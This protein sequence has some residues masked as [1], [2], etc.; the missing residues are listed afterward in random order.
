MAASVEST[1]RAPLPLHGTNRGE[2]QRVAN[3]CAVRLRGKLIE[4][5]APSADRPPRAPLFGVACRPRRAN[6][7]PGP[8]CGRFLSGALTCL[9]P[10]GST[11]GRSHYI[12]QQWQ[13]GRFSFPL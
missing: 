12:S 5:P 8:L 1:S 6:G 10:R 3:L 4:I 13:R 9:V 2:K 11:N 7:A